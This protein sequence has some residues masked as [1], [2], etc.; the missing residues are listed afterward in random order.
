MKK[1]ELR[2]AFVVLVDA[3]LFAVFVLLFQ[4]DR[5]VNGTL[6]SYGLVFSDNWAQPFW[7]TLRISMGLTVAAIFA[8]SFVEL[9]H[10]IFEGKAESSEKAE[11]VSETAKE[12]FGILEEEDTL[13]LSSK[14]RFGKTKKRKKES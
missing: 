4:I 2:A 1:S 11:E 8:I 6:Y 9:P 3:I 14:P 13:T 5:L 7:L 10:S 12:G